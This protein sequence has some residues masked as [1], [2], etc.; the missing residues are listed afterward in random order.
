MSKRKG[1]SARDLH[2]KWLTEDPNY[3][4]AYKDLEEEFS[5]ASALIGARS[6]AGLTQEELARRMNTTQTVI[7]RLE[8]GRAKPSTRTLERFA[9]ATGHRL[10]I[11]FERIEASGTR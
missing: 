11:S 1:I 2:N 4:K 6:A 9:A 5:L 8:S 10:R 3:R 7:A